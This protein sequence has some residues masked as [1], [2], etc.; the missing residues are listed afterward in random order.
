MSKSMPMPGE[1]VK[2]GKTKSKAV[3]QLIMADGSLENSIGYIEEI[4]HTKIIAKNTGGLSVYIPK[5]ITVIDEIFFYDKGGVP[6]E[7]N[8]VFNWKKFN[9]I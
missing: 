2:K 1:I 4:W 7:E 9:W 3:F 6:I 8:T 5:E